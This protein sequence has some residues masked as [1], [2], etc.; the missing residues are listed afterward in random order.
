MARRIVLSVDL[1]LSVEILEYFQEH[2]IEEVKK[3]QSDSELEVDCLI[4]YHNLYWQM[5]LQVDTKWLNL[6]FK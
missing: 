3:K 2:T 5:V 6:H 4:G 1:G